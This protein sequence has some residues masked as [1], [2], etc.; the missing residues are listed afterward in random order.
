MGAM[1][2]LCSTSFEPSP[3]PNPKNFRVVRSMEI[4]GHLLVEVQYPDCTNYEG[5][6]ILLFSNMRLDEL[7]RLGYIDPHFG[8][9]QDRVHPVARFKPTKAGWDMG[10]ETAQNIL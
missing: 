3:N 8:D 9:G 6:K 1:P 5:R 2:K 10:R 4:K 7:E